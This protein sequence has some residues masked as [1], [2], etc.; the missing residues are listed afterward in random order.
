MTSEIPTTAL[1]VCA[2]R[3]LL[4][5]ALHA[6]GIAATPRQRAE[7]WPTAAPITGW[8]ASGVAGTCGCVVGTLDGVVGVEG[9][10]GTE[11]FFDLF[12]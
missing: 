6:G 1:G 7:G 2:R 9:V 8:T 4:N 3:P 5:L 11:G 10:R 12:M